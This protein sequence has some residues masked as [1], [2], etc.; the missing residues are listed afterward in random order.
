MLSKLFKGAF[1]YG[2]INSLQKSITIFLVPLYLAKLS[3]FEY[4]QLEI[5]LAIYAFI[6]HLFMFQLE[7]GFQRFYFDN[8]SNEQ[9]QKRY[10][11]SHL[12]LAFFSNLFGIFLFHFFYDQVI[13]HFFQNEKIS[14]LFFIFFGFD[15]VSRSLNSILLIA[16][17]FKDNKFSFG[18]GALSDTIITSTCAF[19]FLAYFNLG[20][21]GIFL[22]QFIGSLISNFYMIFSVRS[23]LIISFKFS[24]IKNSL[25]YSLYLVPGVMIGWSLSHFSRIF[26]SKAGIGLG[27]IAVYGLAF[28]FSV[29]II[30]VINALKL[31]WQPLSIKII[32]KPGSRRFYSRIFDYYVFLL[33]FA[34]ILIVIAMKPIITFIAPQEYHSSIMYAPSLLAATILNCSTIILGMGISISKKTI[35]SSYATTI[36]ALSNILIMFYGINYFGIL[37]VVVGYYISSFLTALFTLLFSQKLYFIPYRVYTQFFLMFG[38]LLISVYPL[39]INEKFLLYYKITIVLLLLIFT[40]LTLKLDEYIKIKSKLF[41]FLRKE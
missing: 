36:A 26:M 39:N 2:G 22:A 12:I 38:S 11:C 18:V 3:T 29:L 4:G 23:D 31:V 33:M 13:F 1:V 21:V 6:S 32:N 15:L 14:R 35:Y 37:S 9:N 30:L 24:L 17:R 27:E 25:K 5:S 28:K 8:N 34:S 10:L 40:F 20:L 16:L 7:A 41:E 19:V